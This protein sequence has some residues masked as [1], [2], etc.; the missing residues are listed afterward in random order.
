MEKCLLTGKVLVRKLNLKSTRQP[1][2]VIIIDYLFHIQISVKMC[3]VQIRNAVLCLL[4]T[5]Y[6]EHAIVLL[7]PFISNYSDRNFK[8]T[9]W[10]MK[11]ELLR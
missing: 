7:V 11:A 6:M 8:S 1:M 4:Q 5:L 10:N 9:G 2:V 3:S